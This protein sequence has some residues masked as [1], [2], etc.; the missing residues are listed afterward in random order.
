M[1]ERNKRKLF[2]K[3]LYQEEGSKLLAKLSFKKQSSMRSCDISPCGKFLAVSVDSNI[4]I[5]SLD[6]TVRQLI[7]PC[8]SL[9][10]IFVCRQK[11]SKGSKAARFIERLV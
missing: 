8:L 3:N 2:R 11:I 5:F 1:E 6:V 10:A 4:K 7:S 9:L